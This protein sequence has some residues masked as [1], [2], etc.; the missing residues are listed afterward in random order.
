M[1]F[2]ISSCMELAW[3]GDGVQIARCVV[4]ETMG[5][6]DE[7]VLLAIRENWRFPLRI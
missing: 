3:H 5:R 6:I 4:R 1:L 7:C 2:L